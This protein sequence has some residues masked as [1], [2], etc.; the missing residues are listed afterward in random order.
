MGV[1]GAWAEVGVNAGRQDKKGIAHI[2]L[3]GK[4]VA[5]ELNGLANVH[6]RKVLNDSNK[7]KQIARHLHAGESLQDPERVVAYGAHPGLVAYGAQ[8][9]W[10]D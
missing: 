4:A 8:P 10:L 1:T 5:V 7:S 6:V 3:E 9:G 2:P